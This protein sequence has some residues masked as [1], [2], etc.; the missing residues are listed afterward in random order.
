MFLG[1][2]HN[3]ASDTK[4]LALVTKCLLQLNFIHSKSVAS[5]KL[6]IR[7][8]SLDIHKAPSAAKNTQLALQ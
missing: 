3:A 2:P 5:P 6:R 7:V 1:P 8:T 4:S